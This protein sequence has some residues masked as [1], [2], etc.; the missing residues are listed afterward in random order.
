MLHLKV[1]LLF[2]KNVCPGLPCCRWG[3]RD[4]VT[5]LAAAKTRVVLLFRAPLCMNVVQRIK[6]WH[7]VTD[8][9][10]EKRLRRK[11][12][13]FCK[14]HSGSCINVHAYILGR[15]AT[16]GALD[17]LVW[18]FILVSA[19]SVSRGSSVGLVT[20]RTL[21]QMILGFIL[22]RRRRFSVLKNIHTS[23]ILHVASY[24]ARTGSR[25]AGV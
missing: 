23:S 17:W 11:I 10:T 9:Q 21:Q 1:I 12:F 5:A 2:L 7:Q 14:E 8:R 6:R 13:L 18:E 16:D 3:Y 19:R 24:P 4:H 22:C 20:T 25:A 15:C